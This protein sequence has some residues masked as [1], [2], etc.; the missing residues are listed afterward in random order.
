MYFDQLFVCCVIVYSD[1]LLVG[2]SYTVI[3]YHDKVFLILKHREQTLHTKGPTHILEYLPE[4]SVK[5]IRYFLG[6]DPM[7]SSSS[8]RSR[9]GSRLQQQQQQQQKHVQHNP[10]PEPFRPEGFRF[11][12]GD[13]VRN[14]RRVRS[15]S[16]AS[17]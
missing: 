6:N 14:K 3:S 17:R 10:N 7:D 13:P 5:Y 2:S 4:L 12:M 9:A 16:T 8:S 11:G 15:Q 1:Q